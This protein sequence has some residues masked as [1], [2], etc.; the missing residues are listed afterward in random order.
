MKKLLT[1]ATLFLSINA[2]A[3][4]DCTVNVPDR[5][6]FKNQHINVASFHSIKLYN[7]T[8]VDQSY[9][10]SFM[11]CPQNETCKSISKHVL[12]HSGLSFKDE[13]P[14]ET[15]A[16]YHVSGRFQTYATCGIVGSARLSKSAYG[17]VNIY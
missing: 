11:L 15:T 2:Y 6:G 10:Y 8:P 3:D 9:D 17:N 12:L 7:P 1:F 14:L 5:S 16:L 4:A 13:F